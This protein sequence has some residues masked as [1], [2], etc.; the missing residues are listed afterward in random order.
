[1]GDDTILLPAQPYYQPDTSVE[2]LKREQSLVQMA[3]DKAD[4]ESAKF[5][6]EHTEPEVDETDVIIM[7]L[8]HPIDTIRLIYQLKH[9]SMKNWKTTLFGIIAAVPIVLHLFGIVIPTDIASIL[10]AIG[11]IGVGATAKDSNVTGGTIQQ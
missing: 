1:M 2:D 7:F 3:K 10:A 9:I 6:Q 4:D 8:S 5:V 11:T